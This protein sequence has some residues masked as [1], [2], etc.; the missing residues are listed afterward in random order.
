MSLRDLLAPAIAYAAEG[1]PVS[2]II[3]RAWHVEAPRLRTYPDTTRTYLVAGERAPRAGEIVRQPGLAHSLRLIAEGGRD[4][5][6]RGPLAAAIVRN[7]E[8]HGGL[9]SLEDV[10]R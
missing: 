2:E 5:F 6:Y 9:V 10:Q 8:Q 3:A 4:A 7:S 1:F